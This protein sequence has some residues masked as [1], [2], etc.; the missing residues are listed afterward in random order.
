MNT[1]DD[2]NIQIVIETLKEKS[3]NHNRIFV[4]GNGGSASTASHFVNDL[5][6]GLSRRGLIQFDIES[7]SDNT[8]VCTALA[9]DLGYE[10]IYSKQLENKLKKNDLLIAI[11]CSGNSK[12]ILNAV[13]IAKDRG[14]TI[15]GLTGFDGGELLRESDISLHIPTPNNEYGLVENIHLIINHMIFTYFLE[16][17]SL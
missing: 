7:L 10:Y 15:I 16:E 17:S 11:S 12:N 5:G 14:A 2:A 9:N 1:I 6:V 8:A 13:K 4:I 3:L